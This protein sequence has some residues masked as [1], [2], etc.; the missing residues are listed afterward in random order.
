M[1]GM[2]ADADSQ[3]DETLFQLAPDAILVVGGH[4]LIER[5]NPQAEIMFGYAPAELEGHPI[6]RVI[7]ARY[8]H[9]HVAERD[10]YVLAPRTRRMGADLELSALRKDGSE[11]AV[12]I[13][14]GPHKSGTRSVL[15]VVRDVS[16]R[17]SAQKALQQAHDELEQRVAERTHELVRSNRELQD[18]AYVASHDLQ[19]PL[20][21]IQAFGERLKLRLGD[22]VDAQSQDFLTRMQNAAVR[23]QTLIDDLLTFSRVTTR[24]QPF[25]A[26]SLDRI[27]QEV[28]SDL[29]VRI[30]ETHGRV[31]VGPLGTIEADTTQMRQ[32]LQNLIGNALK[33]YDP[34]REHVVRVSSTRTSELIHILVEDTGI[35]FD[36]KYSD[37]IFGLFQRLHARDTYAGS[38]VGLALCRK[39]AERHGGSIVAE[40]RPGSGATFTVELPITHPLAARS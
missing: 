30:E 15:C 13:A 26:V 14:L 10:G 18:F 20:R 6:E 25:H 17:H 33:F 28:L 2:S 38:G 35:G 16:D 19:E 22:T 29:E 21:K 12:E 11:F 37:R 9:T 24:A 1:E 3:I 34:T 4:G 40:G 5:I 39:I 27:L 32:L 36:P 23:M 8:R 7:P 31:E